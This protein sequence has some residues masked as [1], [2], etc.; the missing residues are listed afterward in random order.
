MMTELVDVGDFHGA[1]ALC[2]CS[3]KSPAVRRPGSTPGRGTRL[4]AR[5]A[6]LVV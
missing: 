4:N 3:R 5:L 2:E 1:F 6:E